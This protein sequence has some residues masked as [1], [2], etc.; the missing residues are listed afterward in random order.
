MSPGD[1]RHLIGYLGSR[2]AALAALLFW[3]GAACLLVALVI[4]S[5]FLAL[6]GTG[7]ASD[8]WLLLFPAWGAVAIPL[9]LALKK[10]AAGTA[11][12]ALASTWLALALLALVAMRL[13]GSAT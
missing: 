10:A 9:G 8:G 5:Q 11:L 7:S 2:Q 12:L 1:G 6:P 13:T 4:G 3:L